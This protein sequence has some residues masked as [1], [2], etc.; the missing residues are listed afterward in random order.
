MK[1]APGAYKT[2]K[3]NKKKIQHWHHTH[4]NKYKLNW[5]NL[6]KIGIYYQ[7]QYPGCDTS[8]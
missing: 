3:K 1:R 5:E 2:Q 7:C 8:L 6:N 4:P